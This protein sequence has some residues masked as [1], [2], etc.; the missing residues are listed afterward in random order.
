MN[1][2]LLN[3]QLIHFFNEDI[4]FGDRTSEAIFA[5]EKCEAHFLAKQDGIFAG[6]DILKQG[7]KLLGS[8]IIL[9]MNKKDGDY[10][11]AGEIIGRVKGKTVDLL[12]TERVLLNLIQRMSGIATLTAEAVKQLEGTKT[13][14]CDTRKTTPGL[15]MLEKHAVRCGGGFNHRFRLDDAILIKDNHIA[16]SG[17][18]SKAVRLVR[19]KTGHM[20]KI[21]VEAE[22]MEE[23]REAVEAGANVIM[24]DNCTPEEA[25]VW[26][27][28]TP[29]S[30]YTELSGGIALDNLHEYANTGVDFI[31]AG[32]LT[33]SAPALD[34]SFNIE[35]NGGTKNGK[36]QFV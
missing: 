16:R 29:D 5:D 33:H 19:E 21:E 8:D 26:R 9:E 32:A 15:R 7:Y 2:L 23:V 36:N 34:I 24:F 31:S 22:T 27:R 17:S 4:G 10:V 35:V 12:A 25:A 20:I 11:R 30:V 3:E 6:E 1:K 18:I 14:I 28:E 13:R